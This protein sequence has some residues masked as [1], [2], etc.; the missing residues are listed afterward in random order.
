VGFFDIHWSEEMEEAWGFIQNSLVSV[1]IDIFNG[2]VFFW[3][4]L[5]TF[6]NSSLDQKIAISDCH[7]LII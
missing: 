1:T 6:Y 7:F 4:N 2:I 3:R 5:R